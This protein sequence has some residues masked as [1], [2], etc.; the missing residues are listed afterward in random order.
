MIMMGFNMEKSLFEFDDYKKY[1]VYIL[2]TKGSSRGLRSRLAVHLRCQTAY[3]SQALNGRV[4][5]SL[6]HAI[7][8][9]DFLG[10][11]EEEGTFFMLL[12][13]LG[14]AGSTTLKDY[15]HKQIDL[16]LKRRQII[17]ERIHVKNVLSTETQTIYY[18]S[19]YYAAIHILI[20]IPR[21]QT[22]AAIAEALKLPISTVSDGIEF[23]VSSGLAIFCSGKY[24][25]GASRIHLGQDS[26]LISKHHINWKMRAIHALDVPANQ[27]LHYSSVISLSDNDSSKIRSILLNAIEKTE[28][29]LKESNEENAYCLALDFF[30]IS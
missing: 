17:R 29:I 25:I 3:I 23:L 12:V 4:H 19:W 27:D 30:Q 22:K 18:S 6:E 11:S 21:F 13:H 1:L 10:H 7:R 16:I 15:Y 20:S 9:S 26:P 5:F 8:I 14:R 2:Q 24:K 28:P